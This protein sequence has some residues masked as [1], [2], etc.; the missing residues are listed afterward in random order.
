MEGRK[1][2]LGKFLSRKGVFLKNSRG[3][4]QLGIVMSSPGATC[5]HGTV[6]YLETCLDCWRGLQTCV[7][8]W[9]RESERLTYEKRIG[10][11]VHNRLK[12]R[13]KV[14]D[15][16]QICRHGKNRVYCL[17]CDGRRVC[18]ACRKHVVK[19]RG[20]TCQT[21]Q[22]GGRRMKKGELAT[23]R[24]ET[25]EKAKMNTIQARP[26]KAIILYKFC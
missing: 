19:R 2:D 9:K 20:G 25:I 21:C 4:Q 16:S 15:G 18:A 3:M 6:R 17:Q 22:N 26:A 24:A 8:E 1:T 14:C 5:P 23:L 12:R 7:Q 13:C 10:K 11:C